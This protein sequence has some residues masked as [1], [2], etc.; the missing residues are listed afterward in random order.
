MYPIFTIHPNK[1]MSPGT[2]IIRVFMLVRSLLVISWRTRTL[3]GSIGYMRGYW[4]LIIMEYKI[5]REPE[6]TIAE[7]RIHTAK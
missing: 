4:R 6:P 2:F 7:L 5:N 1:K 3:K